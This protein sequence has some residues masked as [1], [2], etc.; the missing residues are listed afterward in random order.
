MT[1][2][3]SRLSAL[4]ALVFAT[5][6]VMPAQA[7]NTFWVKSNGLD[8]NPCTISQPCAT[9]ARAFA[10]SSPGA[11]IR[12]IDANDYLGLHI[13]HAITIDCT[14]APA[15]AGS[16]IFVE[17]G[18]NDVV[19]L[20][21]LAISGTEANY[22]NGFGVLFTGA[23]TLIL[24]KVKIAGWNFSAGGLEIAPSAAATVVVSDSFITDNGMAGNVLIKPTG[25]APLAVT[26]KNVT[27][28]NSQFGIRADGSGQ[29][30]GQI[31]VDV[32]DSVAADHV[33][34]GFLAYSTPGQAIVQFKITHS[35]AFNNGAHGAVA[36]GA[37]AV[38]LVD[39][40]S[41]T[42]NGIGLSQLNGSLVGSYGNNAINLNTTAEV[43][44]TITP[45][46]RQ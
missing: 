33:N 31:D 1:P 6:F 28:S 37:S 12:C 35:T 43:E 22:A 18:A 14:E 5:L 34:N 32:Q 9:F 46:A 10:A 27:M 3:A 2:F 44:G 30:T 20:R 11:E 7:G 40:S 26:F 16:P 36:N 25:S 29:P 4:A 8:G 45:V 41:L 13:T 39:N 42:K 17:S 23:G 15:T 38:M 21:G 19:V 24:D